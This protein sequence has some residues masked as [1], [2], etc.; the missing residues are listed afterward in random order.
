MTDPCFAFHG[1]PV[2]ISN[3]VASSPLLDYVA[4][5]AVELLELDVSDFERTIK[6]NHSAM[7]IINRS[8][9]LTEVLCVLSDLV[10][11]G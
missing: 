11:L 2:Q 8:L 1:P 5:T 7:Q 4:S 10:W 3:A 6:F 9:H